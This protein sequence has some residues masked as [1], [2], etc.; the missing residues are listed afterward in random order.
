MHH[1]AVARQLLA[2]E[3]DLLRVMWCDNA[4][5]IRAKSL[6]L[7]PR[8]ASAS[9]GNN[10]EALLTELEQAITMTAAL[11]ALPVTL[12]AP[13]AGANLAPVQDVRL[14]ADWSTLTICPRSP[15]IA[16]VIGDMRVAQ[17]PWTHCPREYLR[18]MIAAA[19]EAGITLEAG[20]E[21]EFYLLRPGQ[22]DAFPTPVDQTLYASTVAAQA[23]SRVIGDILQAL[24]T[25]GVP[26][27]QYYP[28][29]GPGQQEITLAHCAPLALADRVVLARETIRAVAAEHGLIASFA[30][31]LFEA[32]T[33][34]GM[35]CHWSLWRDGE[36]LMADAGGQWGLS[37]V[38]AAFMAGLLERL[39][40][41][42]ATTTP[43]VNSY[44]RIRPHE[45]SGAYQAWGVSNKEAAIRLI[46]DPFNDVP[47]HFELKTCDA[48]ANPYIAL[49]TVIAAGLDGV[50]QSATL[51]EPVGIDPGDYSDSQRVEHHI[52]PL[53][54]SLEQAIACF[55][56]DKVLRTAMGEQF[57]TAFLAV[58]RAE[59]EFMKDM[60]LEE[61]RRLLLQ[62]Y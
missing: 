45:W 13:A 5:V 25:Q 2:G 36:S 21:L 57:A 8:L 6:F 46:D 37:V 39:P 7:P 38:A 31:L 10:S 4:N 12:D 58:R 18:R 34:S 23:S 3:F 62:R 40:A 9:G 42:M 47:R 35:H 20:V 14:A 27:E 24:W 59:W 26:V 15:S 17:Q 56:T 33:G 55:E 50:R 19:A 22:D 49:A 43:C 16:T 30:P 53:P 1:E 44:R 54:T 41:V 29:S 28:E 51:P 52:A 60:T 32:A 61:E 48:S 11:Q